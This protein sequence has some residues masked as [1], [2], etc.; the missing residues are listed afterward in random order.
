MKTFKDADGKTWEIR[1]NPHTIDLV[2]DRL[3]V[4]LWEYDQALK[5]LFADPPKA[6]HAAYLL[7]DAQTGGGRVSEE[8]Y[9]Q[10]LNGDVI[11]AMVQAMVDEMLFFSPA[12]IRPKLQELM[13]KA[14]GVQQAVI[15]KGLVKVDKHL[16][17]LD[18]EAVADQVLEAAE[19]ESRLSATN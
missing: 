7:C 11:D 16:A 19:K 9:A 15:R 17:T 6:V 8:E 5:V 13:D 3:G 10:G 14:R 4:N 2:R 12:S 1:I 18:V